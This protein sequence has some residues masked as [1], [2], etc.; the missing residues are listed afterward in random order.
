[1]SWTLKAELV[2]VLLYLVTLQIVNVS[3]TGD[4][5]STPYLKL[6]T[7]GMLLPAPCPETPPG[8]TNGSS[9]SNG[10]AT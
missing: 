6:P 1:M 5:H 2:S 8:T 7:A 10:S 3:G 4:S 9:E